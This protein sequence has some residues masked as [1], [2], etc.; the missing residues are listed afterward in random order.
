MTTKKRLIEM[1]ID[2]FLL[3]LFFHPY[4]WMYVL[5][6]VFQNTQKKGDRSA[7]NWLKSNLSDFFASIDVFNF[8]NVVYEQLHGLWIYSALQLRG[9]QI[10]SNVS[11]VRNVSAPKYIAQTGWP[12]V[13]IVNVADILNVLF[14]PGN[15]MHYH[16]LNYW[17]CSWKVNHVTCCC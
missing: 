2:F 17:V 12:F 13:T 11:K 16:S 6:K 9:K 14:L 8:L 10:K 4:F 1:Y 15:I 7:F 5:I 3:L